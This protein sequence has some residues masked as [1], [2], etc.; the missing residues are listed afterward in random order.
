V[1]LVTSRG[2]RRWVLPKGNIDA[3]LTAHAAAAQEAEEEAGV[4]GATCPTPIGGYRYRK[5]KWTGAS[6]W[7]DVE[8]FPICVTDEL[9]EWKEQHQR[10]RRWFPLA[11]AADAVN[12]PD[13]KALIRNFRPAALQRDIGRW[14]RPTGAATFKEGFRM[15]NW[16]QAL[17]PRQGNFFGLFEAHA[18]TLT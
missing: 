5:T 16:F 10:E 17:M 1:L 12:E 14:I 8:V 11:A 15:F 4:R 6:L 9:S 18:E 3:G 13:L 2:T 7:V